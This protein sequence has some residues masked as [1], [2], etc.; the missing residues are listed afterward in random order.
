MG[1][2]MPVGSD[3]REIICDI[4]ELTYLLTLIP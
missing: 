1:K 4:G 2:Q 3:L